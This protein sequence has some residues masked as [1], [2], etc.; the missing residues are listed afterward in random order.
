VGLKNF[1]IEQDEQFHIPQKSIVSKKSLPPVK[2]KTL[3]VL[4]SE[5]TFQFTELSR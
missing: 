1:S 3:P 4:T 2:G 5:V